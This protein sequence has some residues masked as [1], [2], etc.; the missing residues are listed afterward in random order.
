MAQKAAKIA[1]GDALK[2]SVNRPSSSFFVLDFSPHF[3][4]DRSNTVFAVRSVPS[5]RLGKEVRKPSRF[6]RLQESKAG[7]LYA[8]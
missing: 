6:T 2:P 1:K 8:R 7:A 5:S 4:W 3:T